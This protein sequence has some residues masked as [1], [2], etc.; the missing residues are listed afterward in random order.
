[1]KIITI[2]IFLFTTFLFI[3]NS[4][5]QKKF[6]AI[7]SYG[8]KYELNLTE[9]SGIITAKTYSSSGAL[10][11]NLNGSWSIQNE[12]VY[13]S[14][15][16]LTAK[17]SSGTMKFLVVRDGYGNIQELQD[18]VA[19]RKF[20]PCDKGSDGITNSEND[21]SKYSWNQEKV[22]V[23]GIISVGNQK[24]S[25][26]NLSIKTFRN[27]DKIPEAKTKEE[28]ERFG[29]EKK[30]AW[31][32]YNN[33][34]SKGKKYGIL[35]NFYAVSDSRGL[36]PIG[37]RIPSS[38]DWSI[39]FKELGDDGT[40]YSREANSIKSRNEWANSSITP[41]TKFSNT[42]GFSA[43]P[44]GIRQSNGSF[45]G[46]TLATY[47]WTS[48]ASA[49]AIYADSHQKHIK[50]NLNMNHG[51]SIR[52]IEGEYVKPNFN[53][54]AIIGV[55]Y[56]IS[57]LE[58]A[59]NDFTTEM[60]YSEAVEACSSLGDGWRLP[61]SE[62]L[63]IIADPKYSVPFSRSTSWM[64]GSLGHREPCPNDGRQLKSFYY[65]TQ[66]SIDYNP[67]RVF[68]IYEKNCYQIDKFDQILKIEGAKPRVRAVRS[69]NN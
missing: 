19:S 43:L 1:M 35:Y 64:Y 33:D 51:F 4:Y 59:A 22:S 12:G 68:Y 55:P 61:T 27:G 17:F 26:Q 56:K 62:E 32:Y 38:S 24:W 15:Y 10:L 11:G 54:S 31:C 7:D 66:E 63:T 28:W 48:D 52:I 60:D 47:W 58:V 20:Y 25:S 40:I 44:S 67:V 53:S 16:F 14:A 29:N 13:G 69:I 65:W 34:S 36:A 6:C 41:D 37:W 49:R 8:K 18:V 3:P 39:F 42:S 5:A 23:G 9:G 2:G 57:N 30:P 21:G 46:L 45:E 50:Y